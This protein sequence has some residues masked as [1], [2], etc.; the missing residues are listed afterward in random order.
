M[1]TISL[2]VPDDLFEK[3]KKSSTEDNRSMN[4]FIIDA[5]SKKVKS[6]K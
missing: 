3:M 2:R 6:I 4:S 5:I 1:T